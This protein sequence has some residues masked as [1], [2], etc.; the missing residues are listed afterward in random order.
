MS[1]DGSL[2]RKR[3]LDPYR[4]SVWFVIGIILVAVTSFLRLVWYPVE[5]SDYT[6]FGKPWFDLLQSHAGLTAFIEPF[7]DYAPLY[8]YL[9]KLL[10]FIPVSSLVSEKT[11]SLL[12]DVL[13]AYLGYLIL[14]SA[15]QWS[16][17]SDVLFIAA[18]TL[19]ALPT[20]MMNSS[21][22]GQA[23]ALYSAG[24]M[25][26]LLGILL[27]APL[28]ASI[29][30]GIAISFKVQAIFF[31][32]VL[33]GYLLR[34]KETWKY[35]LVPPLVFLVSVVPAL[36]GGGSPS[37]WL[38]I[39]AV[40]AGEYPWLSVSAQ[41]FFAFLQALPLTPLMT[42]TAFWVGIAVSMSV[43]IIIAY[44]MKRMPELVPGRVVLISLAAALLL[45]Y[46]LPRMH[47]RYFYLADLF[48][49]L[50]AFFRPR[51]WLVPVIVVGA[52]LASYMPFLSDQVSFLSWAEVDLRIPAL[53]LL[54]PI[55]VVVWDVW[56]EK[57][58]FV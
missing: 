34:K 54:I 3:T 40:Q 5:V 12:F 24:V 38:F 27:N 16:L 39:Y 48:A 1:A 50:Y 29:A 7:A 9:L 49:V 33:I 35:L 44:L 52:S 10:T 13:I 25:A 17:R 19:F 28:F 15:S 6:Y 21:L 47:E 57:R 53:L 20:V 36:I 43:A 2:V 14:K 31:A 51:R 56:K 30:F 22:W 18:V 55:A 41:S 37:Y 8:L 4:S 32:P 26:S 58:V 46:L 42:T 11:L 23:D 45:P